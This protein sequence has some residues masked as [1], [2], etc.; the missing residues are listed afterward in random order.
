MDAL[1]ALGRHAEVTGELGALVAANPYRERLR[2]QWMRALYLGGRQSEAL[3]AHREGRRLLAGELGVEPGPELQRLERMILNQDPALGAPASP[4]RPPPAR[5]PARGRRRGVA[6]AAAAAAVVAIAAGAI[7]LTRDGGGGGVT[8][9]PPAVV[10]VDPDSGRVVAS[11]AAGSRPVSVAASDA[12]VW[13]GDARDA[14]VTRI[15]PATRRVVKTIG[16]GAPAV[17]LAA[18]PDGVWVAT[19]GLG[20]VL[21]VDPSLDAVSRRVDLSEP[22]HPIVPS[23]GAVAAAGG[24][25]WAGAFKGMVRLDAATGDV[26]AR[27]DLGS[28]AALQIAVLGDT[29]WATTLRRRAKRVEAGSARIT[30]EFYAGGFVLPVAL[31]RTWAWM[32]GDEGALWRVDPV[33]GVATLSTRVGRGGLVGIALGAGAVWVASYDDRALLRV[34]PASGD[35]TATVPLGGPP[36]DVAFGGGLVWV[37]VQPPGPEG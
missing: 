7:A 29:V 17:D 12:A 13:V 11:I 34:D 26:T 32:G 31:D 15:D 28:A 4:D 37:A 9:T 10:A 19:G 1:I 16:I 24:R 5:A 3:A 27:V 22:G 21:L 8:V 2:G 33:T 23:V 30:A 6:L 20:Q 36:Q 35:V 18:S 25:V 14:T